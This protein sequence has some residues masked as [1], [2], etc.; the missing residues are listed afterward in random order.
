MM[1]DLS[2]NLSKAALLG[3]ALCFG[4]TGLCS[5]AYLPAQ[6]NDGLPIASPKSADFDE[7]RLAAGFE[8]AARLPYSHSLLVLRDGKLVAEQYFHGY[9][10]RS[11]NNLKSVSKSIVSAL[12]GIAFDKK[13]LKSV[14]VPVRDFFPEVFSEMNDPKKN[15]VMLK[16]LLSMSAGFDANDDNAEFRPWHELDVARFALMRPLVSDPGRAFSY[17]S[18][19]TEIV[20]RMLAQASGM[21]L[22]AFAEKYLFAPL[23]IRALGWPTDPL[24]YYQAEIF[25]TSR[26]AAKFGLLFLNQGRHGDQRILS[27]KW[28]RESTTPKIK[29]SEGN[30]LYG[31]YWWMKPDE[32]IPF[33]Y[34]W[35]YG[36]QYIY[37]VPA[38]RL[39]VVMTNDFTQ[40]RPQTDIRAI[41][42]QDVLAA[43]KN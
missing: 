28:I 30:G 12:I 43:A 25:L 10:A 5:N 9:D 18:T 22:K 31:Y 42:E 23:G 8:K 34:A 27:E 1:R 6:L 4:S 24:G 38:K 29:A 32:K 20:A 39:V 11:A 14:D 15:G 26:D 40:R 17:S 41:I 13:I 7:A 36:G 16:H 33:Y 3:F 35:G 21:S 2:R 19:Y 37:V